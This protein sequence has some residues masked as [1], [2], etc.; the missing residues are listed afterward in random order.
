MGAG[1][2]IVPAAALFCEL[3]NEDISN[4]RAVE[5]NVRLINACIYVH[6]LSFFP[7]KGVCV[8]AKSYEN[9]MKSTAV[10]L[11]LIYSF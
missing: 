8:C 1:Q 5:F 7:L 6:V 9:Y 11:T 3:T 2:L 4:G 10:L